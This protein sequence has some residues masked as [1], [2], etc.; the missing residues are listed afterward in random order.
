VFP[1]VFFLLVKSIGRKL[2]IIGF[3]HREMLLRLSD[4]NVLAYLTRLC[5][6]T[7]NDWPKSDEEIEYPNTVKKETLTRD[8]PMDLYSM[9]WIQ[10]RE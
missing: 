4:Y 2:V 5:P 3:R 1:E 8:N 7:P 9:I 6:R 10:E